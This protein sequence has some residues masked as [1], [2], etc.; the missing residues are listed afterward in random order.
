MQH[1]LL[2]LIDQSR[3]VKTIHL[4]CNSCPGQV[5]TWISWPWLVWVMKW[6]W[7]AWPLLCSEAMTLPLVLCGNH[8]QEDLSP[9]FTPQWVLWCPSEAA[10]SSL[11]CAPDV[12][13][14]CLLTAVGIA[15]QP[16]RVEEVEGGFLRPGGKL[17]PL[18]GCNAFLFC[19][20]ARICYIFQGQMPS[21]L[22]LFHCEHCLSGMCWEK[23]SALKIFCD[24]NVTCMHTA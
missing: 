18:S 17:C 10:V 20:G 4:C 5:A 8:W 24:E 9:E 21:L 19:W 16:S 2:G 13:T 6:L 7:T 12:A 23:G 3:F 22:A 11:G 1:V 14:F 15:W